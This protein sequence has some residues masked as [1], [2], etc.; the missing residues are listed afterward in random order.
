MWEQR[1]GYME[2]VLVP[3]NLMGLCSMV[4][5]RDVLLLILHDILSPDL[6]PYIPPSRHP[7]TSANKKKHQVLQRS[8]IMNFMNLPPISLF[9]LEDR[10][11][12]CSFT[13]LSWAALAALLLFWACA[14]V[15]DER[16]VMIQLSMKALHFLSGIQCNSST[17]LMNHFHWSW[18]CL[19][20]IFL[21][22]LSRIHNPYS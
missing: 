1:F 6:Y 3:S 7:Q 18:I 15:E 21:K 11:F 13:T 14:M 8:F 19:M 16:M 10:I 22:L 2:P 5:L 4:I 9:F 12:Q 20:L 17:V